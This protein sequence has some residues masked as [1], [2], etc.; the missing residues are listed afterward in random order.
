MSRF[1]IN[2]RGV[3]YRDLNA[4]VKAAAEA[5]N[6]AIVLRN[7]H[8][9][10]YIG[11]SLRK[12]VKVDVY[13]TPGNDLGAFMDGP[14]VEVHGNAQDGLGN[15]M[16]SGEIVVHGSAGDILAMAMRGGR[17]FVEGDVGY[18]CA[19]HLKE[20][21]AKVPV[22][23]IGGGAQDFFGEY[24]AGGRVVLLGLNGEKLGANFIGTGMH[25]G[26]IFIRGRVD[27]DQLG[28]EV[29]LAEPDE[30][31]RAFLAE[32]V[33]AYGRHFRRDP[34]RV[35]EDGFVKLYPR[36]LRPYGRLYAQ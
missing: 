3:N 7:V 32:V 27:P 4:R 10:R 33:Q 16:N 31:D 34:G 30:S 5:G 36:F 29:G 23:V 21:G 12:P 22:I 28:K 26:V 24:M 13:G 14:T 11:T 8:G 9:Q 15:T 17:V 35:L 6:E 2:A 18:R 1:V 19:I 20:Y 25:G